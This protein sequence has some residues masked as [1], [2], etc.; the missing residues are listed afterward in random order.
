MITTSTVLT[1]TLAKFFGAYM[2]A[3][4]LSLFTGQARWAAVLDEFRDRPGFTYMAGILVYALGA[5]IIMAHNIWADPLAGFIS[6][7]GWVAMIEGLIIIAAPALLLNLAQSMM[8]P[9]FMK[10]FAV[11]VII[12]GALLQAAGFTGTAGIA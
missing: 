9:L 6:L 2:V 4:G 10:I 11:A 8:K 5:A 3:G 12:L 1:L 7:F